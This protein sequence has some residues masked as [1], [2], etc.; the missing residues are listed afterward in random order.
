AKSDEFE[1]FVKGFKTPAIELP[2]PAPVSEL[3]TLTPAPDPE[4]E[5]PALTEAIESPRPLVAPR[6]V[7]SRPDRVVR[8]LGTLAIAAVALIGGLLYWSRGPATRVVEAPANEAP[9]SPTP[10]PPPSAPTSP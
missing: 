6:P 8:V 5:A 4:P 2:T 1:E 10:T 7:A 3:L 9:A